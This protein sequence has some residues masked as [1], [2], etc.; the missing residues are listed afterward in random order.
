MISD[1]E[2]LEQRIDALTV[3]WLDVIADP[4]KTADDAHALA[5][6]VHAA[7]DEQR[8]LRRRLHAGTEGLAKRETK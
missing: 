4:A 2:L 3:Q 1:P 6:A 5:L 7:E 8:E